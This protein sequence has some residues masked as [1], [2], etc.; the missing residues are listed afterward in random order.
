MWLRLKLLLLGVSSLA[1]PGCRSKPAD[2]PKPSVVLLSIDTLRSDRLPVYGYK[3]IATPHLDAL[4]GDAIVFDHVY[5]HYPLTLPS[6]TTILTGLLPP[7][8]GVR[9]NKGYVLGPSH[10]TLAERLRKNGFQTAGIVS[11]MVLG[12]QT[13]IEQGFDRFDD[14]MEGGRPTSPKAAR[15]F[16]QRPGALSVA[17]AKDWLAQVTPGRPFFLFLHLF[18]PHTPRN[19]PEPYASRYKDAYDAEVAYADALVGDFM[20]TLKQ[21]G[22]YDSTLIVLL[23]DHGEGL[24]DHVEEEH[25][26]LLYREALQVP[27]FFKL[28]AQERRGQ[29]IGDA[30]GLMDVAPTVL[31]LLRLDRKGLP[32]SALFEAGGRGERPLYA[33]SLFGLHQ[34]GFS[35]L[36]SIVSENLHYIEAPRAELYDLREDFAERR[37]RLGER[38]PPRSIL[39][40]LTAIG[41]G[42]ES[43][44]EISKEEEER[45]AALGYVGGFEPVDAAPTSRPDPKDHVQQVMELWS[46]MERVGKSDSLAPEKRVL[47]LLAAIGVRKESLSRTVAMNILRAGRPEAA[48]KVLAGFSDSPSAPTQVALGEVATALGRLGD[49]EARFRRALAADPAEARA[50][51]G[52]GIL[53]LTRGQAKEAAPW[54]AAAIERDRTLGEAWNGLGVVHAQAGDYPQ[55]VDAW[56]KAVAL[57]PTLRDAWFNLAVGYQKLGNR[58]A[59]AQALEQYVPLVEGR[60]RAR[61]MAI[62][63][64]LQGG[65]DLNRTP[66]R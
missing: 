63:K 37:N 31:A 52:M 18:E 8:T 43:R 33:E 11:S 55:A 16:A 20:G 41:R 56:Q 9:D 47:E 42:G 23:S 29:R 64:K 44:R 24:G 30:V 5:S 60:E 49:A 13:G 57:D 59:A 34:Y 54:L 66:L 50:H 2:S 51:L 46:E 6:H 1:W 10:V 35:E 22:L 61:A 19:A 25:G 27:L 14:D 39:A 58:Q 21:R 65:I 12:R 26:L 32:G 48:L 62:V 7:E 28:P 15:T 3:G 17:L 40:A 4:A 36:R 45:L 38:T 53:L